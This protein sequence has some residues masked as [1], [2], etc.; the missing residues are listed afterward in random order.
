MDEKRKAE[1]RGLCERATEG[2]W[3]YGR[4]NSIVNT[5]NTKYGQVQ[6]RADA[7]FVIAA[8]TAL[9]EL[10]DDNDAKDR[11]IASLTARLAAV[12]RERDAAV[13][14]SMQLIDVM[15]DNDCPTPNYD[16]EWRG[17]QEPKGETE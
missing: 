10:L 11:E 16:P 6:R 15:C 5:F 14:Y 8:R 7:D 2:P 4:N 12:T 13:D 3:V 9:P 1:L 17:V